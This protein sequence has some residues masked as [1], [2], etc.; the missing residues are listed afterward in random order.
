MV[1][2]EL[3]TSVG[4]NSKCEN[5]LF[6][7]DCLFCLIQSEL[8][9]IFETNFNFPNKSEFEKFDG[10]K[11]DS[12]KNDGNFQKVFFH[13]TFESSISKSE[14]ISLFDESLSSFDKYI[15]IPAGQNC[16]EFCNIV[17]NSPPYIAKEQTT[18]MAKTSISVL[19]NQK[20][21]CVNSEKC[22][23]IEAALDRIFSENFCLMEI[24]L[25]GISD[26]EQSEAGFIGFY[27]LS[28]RSEIL[29]MENEE[30]SLS[31]AKQIF[32]NSFKD[33]SFKLRILRH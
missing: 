4:W 27:H 10:V 16:G 2:G 32:T 21:D 9:S 12:F 28:F 20:D 18:W 24:D 7:A 26:I 17:T 11:I 29:E 25:I 22:V 14:I 15:Y 6:F 31:A 33:R 8:N 1:E 19:T 5:N 13:F 23:E 30:L 3:L